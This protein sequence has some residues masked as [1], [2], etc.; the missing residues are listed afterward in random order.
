[1]ND[2]TQP[3]ARQTKAYPLTFFAPQRVDNVLGHDSGDIMIKTE[4]PTNHDI[5]LLCEAVEG[6]AW[7]RAHHKASQ[8]N[9][10]QRQQMPISVVDETGA[11][12]FDSGDFG[13]GTNVNDYFAQT[14]SPT[15]KKGA[16]SNNKTPHLVPA[17]AM[18]GIK[19]SMP[20]TPTT[21]MKG[22]SIHIE[23][24]YGPKRLA[25]PEGSYLARV[26]KD[27]QGRLKITPVEG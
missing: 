27:S 1:M 11:T 19:I 18:F 4:L 3:I 2:P 26:T 7:I 22:V 23:T 6:D 12:M 5:I 8:W 25:M 17:G 10:L 15:A 16:E 13:I 20:S 24:K 21:W 14:S 9:A